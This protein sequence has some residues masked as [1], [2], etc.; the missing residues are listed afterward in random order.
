VPPPSIGARPGVLVVTPRFP[1]P[2]V[3]G[4]KL[5][6]WNV[7]K[8]LAGS[9]EVD[10]FAFIDPSAAI[11]TAI[12]T[13]DLREVERVCRRVVTQPLQRSQQVQGVAGALI[14]REPMQVGLYR[15]R[16]AHNVIGDLIHVQRPQVVISHLVRML[17]Y[18]QQ[19]PPNRVVLE[20]TDAI[21]M[22]YQ[23]IRRPRSAQE[24]GYVAERRR[25]LNYEI[26][27]VS[28]C[29]ATVVVAQQDAQYLAAHGGQTE[30]VHVITN[31][32]D[33]QQSRARHDKDVVAFL[34]NL[35]STQNEDMV[36][37]FAADIFPLIRAKVPDARFVVIGANP[38]PR[39][40]ALAQQSGI[41]VTGAVSDVSDHLGR[42][43]VS[44]CPMRYGAGVQNKILESMALGVPVVTT[45]IGLEG[46]EASAPAQ[47]LVADAAPE[48][49]AQVVAVLTQPNLR[50][51]LAAAAGA[52]VDQ[53][54]RW[55]T[56]MKQ[57]VD[58]VTTVANRA[59][60]S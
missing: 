29:A 44:V 40:R 48:F 42:A 12:A 3:G 39:V 51:D 6:I 43:A 55:D 19:L 23:R 34:G 11:A 26:A 21:S 45:S 2:P 37:H 58:L 15:N 35:R 18:A 31:G 56:P 25:L 32:T 47:V 59:T 38:S 52:F 5:R 22:N 8:H 9:F 13:E 16:A 24:T 36:L 57:Y 7:I 4:D 28:S 60:E 30:K 27:A 20:M 17:P 46:I 10:L 49:A 41:T 50:Q 33:L 53:N 14:R 1:Y 54:F